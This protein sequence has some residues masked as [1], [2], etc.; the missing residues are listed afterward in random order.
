MQYCSTPLAVLVAA[1]WVVAALVGAE[2]VGAV[3]V[4]AVLVVAALAVAVLVVAALVAAARVVVAR[5]VA[6]LALHLHTYSALF[7]AASPHLEPDIA[8][9]HSRFLRLDTSPSLPAPLLY[10]SFDCR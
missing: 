5:V 2:L 1:A 9:L 7:V 3:L 8:N 10:L 4:V 6:A